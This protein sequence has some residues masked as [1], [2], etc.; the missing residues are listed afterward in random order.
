MDV[1]LN[2]K[3]IRLLIFNEG[4]QKLFAQAQHVFNKNREEI[5][6]VQIY[7]LRK[8]LNNLDDWLKKLKQ[9]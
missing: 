8:L 1:N 2:H 3:K 4:A 7:C 6:L 9:I 5:V